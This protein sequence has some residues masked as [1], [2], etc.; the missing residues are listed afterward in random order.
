MNTAVN[1]GVLRERPHAHANLKRAAAFTAAMAV[2]AISAST[3]AALLYDKD[4]VQFDVF[5]KVQAAFVNDYAYQEI[6]RSDTSSDNTV[7]AYT[8]LG[9]AGRSQ[10]VNGVDAIMMA[11]WE[12]SN[13]QESGNNILDHTRYL[14]VGVDAYQ[15]GTLILGRGDGAYY[16]VAGATDIFNVISGNASD[17]YLLG[18]QRPGQIMYSLR[19]MSWDLKLSYMFATDELGL[20]PLKAKRGWGAAVSTKFGDNITFAYGIDYTDFSYDPTCRTASEEFFAPMLAWDNRTYEEALEK[21]RREHV[22]DKT[23]F[24]AALSYGVLGQGLYAALVVG[25]T[26]Y[27]YLSHHIYTLDTAINYT[28]NNGV[29]LSLGYGNKSYDDEQVIHELNVGIAYNINHAF[30]IFAEAQFDLDSKAYEF[31]GYNTSRALNLGEDKYVIG[32][33]MNF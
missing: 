28:F 27:D 30:K 32:A 13:N 15:Y 11:E 25:A 16:T 1:S 29:S 23:E 17:Y 21:S 12:S 4:G 10:I 31:Y 19:G 20:T 26:D 24:G 22:G 3:Q 7:Y 9:L 5:G 18:D 33:E 8:R 2:G 14:F 6:A